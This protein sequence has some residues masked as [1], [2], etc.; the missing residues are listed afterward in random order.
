VCSSNSVYRTNSRLQDLLDHVSNSSRRLSDV[1]DCIIGRGRP[2]FSLALHLNEVH[3]Y[4]RA[5]L[6]S[7]WVVQN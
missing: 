6:S 4:E 5:F 1:L 2:S 3:G 7:A